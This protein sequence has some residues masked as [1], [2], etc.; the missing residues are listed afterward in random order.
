MIWETPADH[1]PDSW[2]T[3][4]K[5]AGVEGERDRAREREDNKRRRSRTGMV[6]EFPVHKT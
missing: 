5:E 2:Y 3:K 4:D 6:L 1:N